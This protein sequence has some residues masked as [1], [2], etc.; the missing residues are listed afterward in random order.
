MRETAGGTS[1]SNRNSSGKPPIERNIGGGKRNTNDKG[2]PQSESDIG[3]R[4]NMTVAIM[5]RPPT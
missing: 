1:R 2:K 4:R 5:W 3:G